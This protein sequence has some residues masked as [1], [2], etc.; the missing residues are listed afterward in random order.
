MKQQF[1]KC[2]VLGGMLLLC[3][4]LT[5]NLVMSGT[6]VS[7][8][9][10]E[11]APTWLI[12]SSGFTTAPTLTFDSGEKYFFAQ[13]SLFTGQN[14]NAAGEYKINIWDNSTQ[15]ILS[16]QW[17]LNIKQVGDTNTFTID[18]TSYLAS[19]AS[20]G[21]VFSGADVYNWVE[22]TD[23]VAGGATYNNSGTVYNFT[24]ISDDTS[25]LVPEPSLIL[26]LGIGLGAVCL[27]ESRIRK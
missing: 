6:L 8:E 5:P 1:K 9:I 13:G 20:V 16:D 11:I 27:V 19:G 15:T 17:Y 26:L 4:L 2:T 3:A 18:A 22:G 23:G 7:I 10:T 25:T 24:F 14:K 12:E 21:N